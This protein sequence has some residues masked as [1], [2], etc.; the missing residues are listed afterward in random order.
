MGRRKDTDFL[1]PY[2]AMNYEGTT[3]YGPLIR[4]GLPQE[5]VRSPHARSEGGEFA[6][7]GGRAGPGTLQSP[8]GIAE[9]VRYG[10]R[11]QASES[12]PKPLLEFD[13]FGKSVHRMMDSPQIG[14]IVKLEEAERKAYGGTPFGD[15]CL[16]ARNMVAAEPGARFLFL[17][18]GDWDHH[19]NIY[20]K[21]VEGRCSAVCEGTRRRPFRSAVRFEADE[22]EGRLTATR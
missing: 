9:P 5:R 16:L 8:L 1:P 12:T 17:T 11:T 3:M 13:T 4:G 14:K 10:S 18:H 7:H 15:S 2:I 22:I 19:S 6:L 20:G 21:D